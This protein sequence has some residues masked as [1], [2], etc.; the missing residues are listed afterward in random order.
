MT[1]LERFH[2]HR[3]HCMACGN[4]KYVAGHV[5]RLCSEGKRLWFEHERSAAVANPVDDSREPRQPWRP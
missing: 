3:R 5:E 1:A 4:W 2:E